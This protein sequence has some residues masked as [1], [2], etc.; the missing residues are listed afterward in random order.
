MI[1][2]TY[3]EEEIIF[4]LKGKAEFTLREETKVVG[5]NSTL[6]CPSGVLHGIR[7]VGDT[8]LRYAIIKGNYPAERGT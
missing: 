5:S 3:P 6:F 1:R 8:P 7:N 2:G 4:I